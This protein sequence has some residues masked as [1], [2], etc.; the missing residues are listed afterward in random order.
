MQL[1]IEKQ[2]GMLVVPTGSLKPGIYFYTI[3]V[4]GLRS[5]TKQLVKS[6]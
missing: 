6:E 2:E 5:T 1:P 4:D 3:Y